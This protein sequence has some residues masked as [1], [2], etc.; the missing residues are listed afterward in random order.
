[1]SKQPDKHMKP[2]NG[3]NSYVAPLARFEYQM[4][5]MLETFSELGEAP[6]MFNKN[7]NYVYYEMIQGF[8]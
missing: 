5:I 6:W 1:M 8:V 2:H 3:R 4:E 7:R